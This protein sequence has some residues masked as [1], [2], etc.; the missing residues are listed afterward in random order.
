MT[1]AGLIGVPAGSYIS[2]NIRRSIPNADPIVSGVTLLSSVPGETNASWYVSLLQFSLFSAV[3]WIPGSSSQRK[4]L[5]LS[6]IHRRAPSQLQLG[7][8]RQQTAVKFGIYTILQTENWIGGSIL[9][10]CIRFFFVWQVNSWRHDDV[11]HRR[12]S[13]QLRVRSSGTFARYFLH[14]KFDELF[15]ALSHEVKPLRGFWFHPRS[16][17]AMR[18]ETPSRRS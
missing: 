8:N 2:Q 11:H 9:H 12:Q 6:D 7:S 16:L 17:W 15:R 1:F 3:R 18:L 4:C 14:L 10:T 13:P 5:S